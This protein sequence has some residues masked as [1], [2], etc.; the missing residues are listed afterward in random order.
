MLAAAVPLF[1]CARQLDLDFWFDEQYTISNFVSKPFTEIATSYPVPNNHVFYSLILRPFYLIAETE[2]I[3]RLPSF[4]FSTGTLYLVFCLGRR[5]S[6]VTAGCAATMTLGMM[7]MFQNYTMQVRGYG[8][9][10]FLATC[11]AY[12]ALRRHDETISLRRRIAIGLAGA[13]FL[14]VIPTNL[15]F[16]ATLTLIAVLWTYWISRCWKQAAWD[17]MTWLCGG[18]LGALCYLPIWSAVWGQARAVENPLGVTWTLTHQLLLAAL[19]DFVPLII[20]AAVG[21]V[22]LARR[23]RNQNDLALPMIALALL[24]GPL[25]LTAI[26]RISPFVRN[27]TPALPLLALGMGWLIAEAVV[28]FQTQFLRRIQYLYSRV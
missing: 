26:L 13:A 25:Y 12:L 28:A 22:C 17:L 24:A 20:V 9:S 11:L 1:F 7:Q 19:R 2:V 23:K 14:Y 8:L 15:L 5:W 27:F 4:L 6:G 21:L 10:M 16:L 3:L 18:L